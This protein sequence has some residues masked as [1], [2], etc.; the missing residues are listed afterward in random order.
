MTKD[1]KVRTPR[2]PVTRRK[3]LAAAS[4]TVAA[5]A[6]KQSTEPALAAGTVTLAN[7]ILSPSND[8]TLPTFLHNA[9][10]ATFKH[11]D[12]AVV[13]LSDNGPGLYGS[14]NFAQTPQVP[15]SVGIY[16][17][18]GSAGGIGVHG[19]CD[20]SS[21]TGVRGTGGGTSSIGVLGEIPS[22]SSANGIAIYGL[23]Y[24]TYAG[25]G[26]GAGGFGLYGLSAKGHGLVGAVATAGAAAVVGAT[27]GVSGAFA[28]AFYGPVIMQDSLTVFGAKSAALPHPDGSRRLVY[29]VESPD[30][31]LEDFGE[32]ALDCGRADVTVDPH[33]A[34]VAD[35]EKYHV[36]LTEYENH[37]ALYVTNRTTNGFSVQT[38]DASANGTFSWR[39]VARRKDIHVGRWSK[40]HIPP[41]PDRPN[42]PVM[43]AVRCKQT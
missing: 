33:F 23:N 7:G 28:G 8:E 19:L 37:N 27:N 30:S 18:H 42:L 43:T 5:L 34:A 11:D 2:G 1:G 24:S 40:V 31:W 41:E 20:K 39:I 17:D 32:A 14:V 10:N 3:I 9:A 6:V 15:F 26:P 4:A 16:G 29:C 38:K 35:M 13:G 36:F 12:A 25:P 21:G 22:N